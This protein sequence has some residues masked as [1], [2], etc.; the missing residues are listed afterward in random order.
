ME[1]TETLRAE[2]PPEVTIIPATKLSLQNNALLKDRTRVRVAAYC[3]VSTDDESQEESFAGQCRYFTNY[4]TFHPG[5]TLVGV[6]ADHGKSGTSRKGRTDFNRM[7]EKAKAGEIDYIIAKSI[8]RFARNTIDILSCTQELRRMS[9]PVGIFFEK[10]HLDTLDAKTDIFLSLYSG[11]SQGESQSISEN[12]RWSFQKRFREGKTT[13]SPN[14]ILGYR[15][16]NDGHWEIDDAGAEIVICI[17]RRFNEGTSARKIAQELNE[18]GYKTKYGNPWKADSVYRILENEKYAGDIISQKTFTESFL[19]HKAVKNTG[20][21]AQYYAPNHHPAIIPR[22]M[23]KKTQEL[24]LLRRGK[25]K[26]SDVEVGEERILIGQ[27]TSDLNGQQIGRAMLENGKRGTD[28]EPFHLLRCACGKKMKRMTYK[29]V[30]YKNASSSFPNSRLEQEKERYIVQ[31]AVWKCPGANGKNGSAHSPC[32]ARTLPE[33]SIEQSFMEMLYHLR[34]DYLLRQD[35]SD[36]AQG[37]SSLFQ[38]IPAQ[39]RN[40]GFLQQQLHLIDLELDE[41]GQERQEISAQAQHCLALME[42]YPSQS[43]EYSRYASMCTQYRLRID[44]LTEAM[45]KKAAE[46]ESLR[47]SFDKIESMRRNYEAFLGELQALPDKSMV[48]YEEKRNLDQRA[49][50]SRQSAA[51]NRGK[52]NKAKDGAAAW[53]EYGPLKFD[54]RIFRSFVISMRAEGDSVCYGMSFGL[55]ISS[56]GNSRPFRVL[57]GEK[58]EDRK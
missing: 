51:K 55:M 56:A 39:K 40:S 8:S 24:L 43:I 46:R 47:Q 4:I 57:E 6:F 16:G 11:F 49:E 21:A 1:M 53:S 58:G 14:R 42:R 3:R 22:E 28:P 26:L 37:F 45:D 30:C 23:W 9:P 7:M 5:W 31:Y 20:E 18:K 34:A 10:E 2:R 52:D 35:G 44:D 12:I 13:V 32:K 19:T 27:N 50:L 48:T 54:E 33:S 15:K 17:Y 25:R 29:K 36:I 41:I 38:N